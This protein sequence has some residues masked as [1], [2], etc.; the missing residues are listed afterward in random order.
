[1]KTDKL[2]KWYLDYRLIRER[3]SICCHAIDSKGKCM[4]VL[5]DNDYHIHLKEYLDKDTFVYQCHHYLI[6]K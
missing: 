3:C 2:N 5:E 6:R 4:C 1:M